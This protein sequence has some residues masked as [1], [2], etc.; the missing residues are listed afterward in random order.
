MKPKCI[1]FEG[2]RSSTQTT[3]SY[4]VIG[5]LISAWIRYLLN[6]FNSVQTVKTARLAMLNQMLQRQQ[7][8]VKLFLSKPVKNDTFMVLVV[9]IVNKSFEIYNKDFSK[10]FPRKKNE[11]IY[12]KKNL[13][14]EN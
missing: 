3:F 5:F 2:L 14:R 8:E 1:S 9:Q 11:T 6:Y 13:F 4:P 7:I 12:I 10:S